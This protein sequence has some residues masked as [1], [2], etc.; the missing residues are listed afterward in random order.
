[1]TAGAQARRPA[2]VLAVPPRD[3]VE[4]ESTRVYAGDDPLV[5]DAMRH[6]RLHGT[7]P[8]G[9][10]ELL[11]VIPAS[12]RSLETRFKKA[13]GRTL[14]QEIVR[15]RLAHARAL[16]RTSRLTVSDVASRSGFGS[17]QRFHETFMAAE[18]VSPGVYRRT[19]GA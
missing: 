10:P 6:I 1:M 19:R 8:M 11:A 3:V 13:T 17:A 2:R 5:Q 4:R 9:I 12:R 14:K 15:V 7:E 18:G 16:L